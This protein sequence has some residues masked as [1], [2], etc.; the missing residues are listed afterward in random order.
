MAV[1]ASAPRTANWLHLPAPFI[2]LGVTAPAYSE[3]LHPPPEIPRSFKTLEINEEF[4]YSSKLFN[5]FENFR[6]P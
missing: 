1:P 2:L 4:E 5:S 3:G 6:D